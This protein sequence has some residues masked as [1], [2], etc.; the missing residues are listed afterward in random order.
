MALL[1]PKAKEAAVGDA[2]CG[3]DEF[4]EISPVELAARLDRLSLLKEILEV[5]WLGT[6]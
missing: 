4:E 5:D 6:S 3:E 1:V 2:A